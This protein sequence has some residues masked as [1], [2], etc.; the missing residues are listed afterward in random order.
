MRAHPLLAESTVP[1]HFDA[2]YV[3]TTFCLPVTRELPLR[4]VA[5]AR[6]ATLIR[7]RLLADCRTNLHLCTEMV[8]YKAL[9]S[10]LAAALSMQIRVTHARYDVTAAIDVVN[11][12]AGLT[13]NSSAMW[14]HACHMRQARTRQ[15]GFIAASAPAMG[16][17]SYT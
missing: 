15:R 9:L 1:R 7:E 5:H 10:Y 2:V 11:N 14:L 6:I 8:G 16:E 12:T 13:V 17:R 4:S 3:D